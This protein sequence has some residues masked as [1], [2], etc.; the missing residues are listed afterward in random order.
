LTVGSTNMFNEP[1]GNSRA[2]AFYPRIG[3]IGD[4]SG[5]GRREE[6]VPGVEVLVR[7]TSA[8][9]SRPW[10]AVIVPETAGYERSGGSVTS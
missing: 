2:G 5:G 1:V 6:G 10:P 4:D 3:Q 9:R 8:S 7:W